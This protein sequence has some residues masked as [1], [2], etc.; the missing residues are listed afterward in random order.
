M[1]LLPNLFPK[2][3]VQV[4]SATGGP[5]VVHLLF[6]SIKFYWNMASPIYFWL[7]TLF[8]CDTYGQQHAW[9]SKP[10]ILILGAFP[11][12]V[13]RLAWNFTLVC[14][15]TICAFYCKLKKILQSS[16]SISCWYKRK[17]PKTSMVKS[18][19]LLSLGSLYTTTL[20]SIP[21]KPIVPSLC[22]LISVGSMLQ[23]SCGKGQVL[24]WIN[25]RT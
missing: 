3:G 9:L 16:R 23:N 14:G 7:S 22:S 15:Y 2:L 19:N 13:H 5:D 21:N 1:A 17:G 10:Y 11:E 24:L 12:K 18:F 6:I 25:I 20:G 4:L 8:S